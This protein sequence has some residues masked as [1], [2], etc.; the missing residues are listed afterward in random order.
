MTNVIEK[1]GKVLR[2]SFNFTD[3]SFEEDIIEIGNDSDYKTYAELIGSRLIDVV[4]FDEVYDIIVDDEG[5]LVSENPVFEI[6]TENGDVQLAGKLLFMK[7]VETDDGLENV[8]MDAGE[9]LDL[10]LRLKDKVE[11]F[12][13]VK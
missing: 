3:H 8:G 2:Y 4:P 1:A 10:L 11:I 6:E 5:L 7:R 12:G 9:C 13:M